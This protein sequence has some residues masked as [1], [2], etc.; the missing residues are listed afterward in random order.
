MSIWLYFSALASAQLCEGIAEPVIDVHLHAYLEDPR[1]VARVPNLGTG[2]PNTATD[3]RSHREQTIAA[4]RRLGIV[5]GLVMGGSHDAERAMVAADPQRLRRGYRIGIPSPDDMAEIR[6]LHTRGELAMIGEVSPQYEGVGPD[7]P[8]LEPLWSLAEELQIPIGFHIG[9]GPPVSAAPNHPAAIGDPLL[10][11]PVLMRHPRLRLILMHAGFPFADNVE[12]L[13]GRYPN[14]HVDLGAIHWAEHRPAF[15][16]FLR[17]LVEGGF[18][19]RIM[20]GSDQMVW[21]DA[22]EQSLQAYREADYL[23]AA[24]RRDILFNNAVRFFGWAELAG[25]GRS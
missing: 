19:R 3:G 22:I 24:Q 1:L 9:R 7:D 5:R 8:R 4:L 16:R 13:L 17:R 15:H 23:T 21:P 11:E 2:A 25:C 20:F 14:V 18:A 10:L 6:R 12:A